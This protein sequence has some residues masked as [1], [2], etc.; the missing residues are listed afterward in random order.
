[1]NCDI[2]DARFGSEYGL[3]SYLIKM[4]EYFRWE[5]G[6]GYACSIDHQA[7]GDWLSE[8]E[9]LWK[10]LEEREF[11]PVSIAGEEFPPFASKQINAVLNP[12]GLVY[13]GG[14]GLFGKPHFFLAELVHQVEYP[15]YSL[16]IAGREL[17]RDLT[18]PPA[19]TQDGI[20]YLRRESLRQMLWEKLENWRWHKRDTPLGRAFACYGFDQDLN[21]ALERMTEDELEQVLL[22]EQG[23]WLAG[24]W[25]GAGWNRMLADL[26]HTP[27]ELA[28]RA[29]RDHIADCWVTLP[30]MLESQ[31]LSSLHFFIGNLSAMRKTLFPG[32]RTA[33]DQWFENA[34]SAVLTSLAIRGLEHWQTVARTMLQLYAEQGKEAAAAIA[35]LVEKSSL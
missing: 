2:S 21:A 7:V 30:N 16:V 19:M 27:A 24:D 33:Y 1:M 22:H 28:V 8:R 29:V 3:C 18:S 10:G 6:L 11:V 26:L 13:S 25:L 35:K 31:R 20:I 9:Q 32:L 12:H 17:A 5:R 23:E 34:D 14:I 4:R 15:G